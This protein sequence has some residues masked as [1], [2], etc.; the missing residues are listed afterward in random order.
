MEQCHKGSDHKKVISDREDQLSVGDCDEVLIRH[1]FPG[2]E[3]ESLSDEERARYMVDVEWLENRISRMHAN[4]IA[5]AFGG[6]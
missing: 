2:V 5:D 1:Y 4:A 3:V 6:E